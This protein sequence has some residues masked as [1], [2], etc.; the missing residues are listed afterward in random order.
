MPDRTIDPLTRTDWEL[1]V[2][3]DLHRLGLI[4]GQAM[5]SGDHDLAISATS[6]R[7]E[8]LL[9]VRKALHR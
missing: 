1:E 7:L 2:Y 8:L 5:C 6:Q 9:K 4:A 3:C